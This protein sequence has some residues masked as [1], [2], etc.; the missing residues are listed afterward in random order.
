MFGYCGSCGSKLYPLD[1]DYIK[2]FGICSHCVTVAR[3]AK[4]R[5]NHCDKIAVGALVKGPDGE[6]VAKYKCETHGMFS[7]P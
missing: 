1:D 7:F 3:K 6:W 5:C 4:A 2:A